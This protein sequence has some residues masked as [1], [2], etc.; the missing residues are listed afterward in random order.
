MA[1]SSAVSEN[2]NQYFSFIELPSICLQQL[3][4]SL[5]RLGLSA[6]PSIDHAR[7]DGPI[8][9]ATPEPVPNTQRFLHHKMGDVVGN[10][11]VVSNAFDKEI[12]AVVAR[13][14]CL[15]SSITVE[16]LRR[17]LHGPIQF[18][19]RAHSLVALYQLAT[20]LPLLRLY[21]Q[22]RNR[23]R[24]E[25]LD[26]DRLAGLLAVAVGAILDARECLV[27]LGDQLALAVTGAQF[28]R[29]V[30]LRRSPIGEIRVILILV[31]EVL[32]GLL[33]LLENIL[34]PSKQLL[35]EILTLAIVH[36][37]LF[38][39]RPIGLALI[40][41]HLSSG[42]QAQISL[43]LFANFEARPALYSAAQSAST[44]KAQ[45]YDSDHKNVTK[46]VIA[47]K[48]RRNS[49]R[50][51]TRIDRIP[52]VRAHLRGGVGLHLGEFHL[53]S[54]LDFSKHLVK[55]RTAGAVLEA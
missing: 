5:R 4:R 36:E 27:D 8:R 55:Q 23:P 34:S 32:E 16:A 49:F 38:V 47:A 42:S 51:D 40:S 18:P 14:Q 17:Q 29:P 2:A 1:L 44:A 15:V 19:A 35:A 28:N 39:G 53:Y 41:T 21:R 7:E 50:F 13:N 11:E 48:L 6:S 12:H 25:A 45:V 37:R 54:E 26:R 33:C 20:L 30:G 24:F 52:A 43:F 9:N 46:S 31:L 22:R 3:L 10:R